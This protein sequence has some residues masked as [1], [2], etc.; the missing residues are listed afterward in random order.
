[1]GTDVKSTFSELESLDAKGELESAFRDS[2]SC[3]D[4]TGTN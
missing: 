2:S 4:L 3:S 1:M